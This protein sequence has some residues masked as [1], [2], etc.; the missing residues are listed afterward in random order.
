MGLKGKIIIIFASSIVALTL[1]S[2][3][4]SLWEETLFIKGTVNVKRPQYTE[5]IIPIL[6]LLNE[7]VTDT[8]YESSITEISTDISF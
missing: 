1:L 2:A 6:P 4:Y 3:G 5:K 7:T 8:I